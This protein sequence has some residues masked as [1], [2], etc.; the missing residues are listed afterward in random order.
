MLPMGSN[1]GRH[2]LLSINE[3]GVKLCLRREREKPGPPMG[4][5][6]LGTDQCFQDEIKAMG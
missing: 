2:L 4:G 6:G 5:K 1:G 3:E